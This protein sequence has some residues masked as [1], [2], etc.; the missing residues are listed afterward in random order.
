SF[1]GGTTRTLKGS[2]IES[3]NVIY[4]KL[5]E[6]AKLLGH[7]AAPG[8]EDK[9]KVFAKYL[10][11]LPTFSQIGE[12]RVT[13]VSETSTK[14]LVVYS[15]RLSGS[16]F[17]CKLANC[18]AA[19]EQRLENEEEPKDS[20]RSAKGASSTTKKKRRISAK[21][22]DTPAP[23]SRDSAG[24]AANGDDEKGRGSG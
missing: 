11:T 9:R 18:V 24:S 2:S 13:A 20:S 12:P 15:E 21:P 10:A 3:G 4:Q 8:H 17:F 19:R 6:G 5:T 16:R 23:R 14:D 7:V 22:E 1:E